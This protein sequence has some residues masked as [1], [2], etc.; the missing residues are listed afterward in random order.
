MFPPTN[1]TLI[2]NTFYSMLNKSVI[3][4]SQQNWG[5][6]P[7]LSCSTYLVPKQHFFQIVSDSEV[8]KHIMFHKNVYKANYIKFW[9]QEIMIHVTGH[10]V[11]KPHTS[12]TSLCPHTVLKHVLKHWPPWKGSY[13][14]HQRLIQSIKMDTAVVQTN[15]VFRKQLWIISTFKTPFSFL[16]YLT[17]D[18]CKI[19]IQFLWLNIV[20]CVVWLSQVVSNPTTSSINCHMLSGTVGGIWIGDWIY[21]TLITHNYN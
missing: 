5:T 15:L 1:T 4:C 16:S 20:T 6:L 9:Q 14:I 21:W 2:R 11:S 12:G 7:I 10:S 17:T 3:S 13:S 8:D 18:I 19:T